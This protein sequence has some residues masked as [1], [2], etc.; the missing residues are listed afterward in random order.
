MD[1]ALKSFLDE[2][3]TYLEKQRKKAIRINYVYKIV[4]PLRSLLNAAF[5]VLVFINVIAPIFIPLLII[6][7]V[8]ALLFSILNDPKEVFESRL[9]NRVLPEI[10]KHVNPSFQYASEGYN[11]TT[12]QESKL[13]SKGFFKNT[14]KL[15]G[16]DYVKGKI[17]NIDV[18]FFEIQFFKEVV[19]YA[20]TAGGCLLSLILIPVELFKNIF[21][22]DTQPDELFVG[23]VRDTNIFYSGFFMYADFHKDF[24][25]KVLMIPKKNDRIKDKMFELLEPKNLGTISMEN[26][27]IDNQYNIYSSNPT[28]GYYV[29]SQSL[30]DKIHS[31]SEKERALPIISLIN[32]KMYFIIPW[33]KNFFSVNLFSKIESGDYFLP[34]LNEVKS[35]ETII[36]DLNLDTRIWTKV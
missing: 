9:K 35:F 4:K 3:A 27:Y 29:L 33:N 16:E 15:K 1:D 7:G 2:K 18:E 34:Y 24:N 32:G 22:G 25:G 36:K 8:L 13:L 11:G 6:V 19:N 30:I 20:K 10:F 28:L 23:V 21:H 12:L 26:P 31:M 14:V 17:N 5:V